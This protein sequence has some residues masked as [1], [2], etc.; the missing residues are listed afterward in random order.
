MTFEQLK[1]KFEEFGFDLEHYKG[2]NLYTCREIG[3][4]NIKYEEH[5]RAAIEA[6]LELLE[7]NKRHT[8]EMMSQEI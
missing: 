2:N 6:R 8:E 3:T 1:K 4:T 7:E 5:G